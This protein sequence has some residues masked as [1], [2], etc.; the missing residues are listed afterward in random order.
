MRDSE[1]DAYGESN[2]HIHADSYTNCDGNCHIH[3][4]SDRDGNCHIHSDSDGDSN[5]HRITAAYTDAKTSSDTAATT[6]RSVGCSKFGNSRASLASSRNGRRASVPYAP[7]FTE[8]LPR[9]P[10]SNWKV[11]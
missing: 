7:G 2:S 6:I 8:K 11:A 1:P 9:F 5:C 10:I 4:D 3:S